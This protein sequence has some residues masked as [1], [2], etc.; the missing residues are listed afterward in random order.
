MTRRLLLLLLLLHSGAGVRLPAQSASPPND[1]VVLQNG[2]SVACRIVEAT[3]EMVRIEY[4]PAGAVG[5]LTRAVPW[6][7]VRHA[8]FVMDEEFRALLKAT[9][10]KKDGAKLAARW[11]TGQ[12]LLGRPNHP[13]GELGLV[14]AAACLASPDAEMKT[15]ALEI[16]EALDAGDWSQPRR[17]RAR[18]LRLEALV[19]LNRQSEATTQAQKMAADDHEE[20]ESRLRAMLFLGRA[21]FAALRKL[22]EENPRWEEDDLVEPERH[23]LF[24]ESVEYF[25]RPSLFF[26][27]REAEAAQGL[28]QAAEVFQFDRDLSAAADCARDIL[29]LYAATPQAQQAAELLA[30]HKLPTEPVVEQAVMPEVKEEPKKTAPERPAEPEVT[31]RKR[32]EKPG[33]PQPQS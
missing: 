10:V 19:A 13:A 8:D 24:H 32:Y 9:D 17:A 3:A 31:R 28:W 23:R 6:A 11:Q 25:I 2:A 22:E 26:G 18:L 16:C 5:L 21:N 30:K 1:V 29:H 7:E 20:E 14:Y 33:T 15:K 4:R 12:P 27:T